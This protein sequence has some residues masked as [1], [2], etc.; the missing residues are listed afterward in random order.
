MSSHNI[1][2]GKNDFKNR[3]IALEILVEQGAI[4]CK[5]HKFQVTRKLLYRRRCYT[6]RNR[7]HGIC[8]YLQ[9]ESSYED[10]GCRRQK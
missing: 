2:P 8:P 10:S 5:K 6:G 1:H 4:C 3:R 7:N 9:F